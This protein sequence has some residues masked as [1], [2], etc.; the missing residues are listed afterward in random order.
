ML[1]D[2]LWCGSFDQRIMTIG[3]SKGD[4]RKNGRAREGAHIRCDAC[5]RHRR[6]PEHGNDGFDCYKLHDASVGCHP[7]PRCSGLH[8]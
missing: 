8:T 2:M 4:A 3:G 6:N 7:E 5:R 1:W